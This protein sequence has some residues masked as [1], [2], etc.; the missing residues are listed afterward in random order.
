MVAMA[1]LRRC[2]FEDMRSATCRRSHN[3]ARYT[4]SAKFAQYFKQSPDRLGQTEVRAYE[5]CRLATG[6]SWADFNVVV[7]ALN[8]SLRSPSGTQA[9]P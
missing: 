3:A 6:T 1:A 5:I 9:S 2:M 4:R 7:S 8:P